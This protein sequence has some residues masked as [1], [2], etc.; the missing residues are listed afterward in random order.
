MRLLILGGTGFL[1]R[2][3]VEAALACGHAVTT[4]TRG[5]TNPD[6]HPQTERLHGDR[7]GALDPLR[8]REWD[9]VIDTSG[10]D[11]RAV[12]ASAAPLAQT[13]VYCFVS[14]R[15]VYADFRPGRRV[16]LIDARDLAEWMIRLVEA[17]V[18][19]IYNAVGTFTMGEVLLTCACV[20][21]SGATFRWVAEDVLLAAGVAPW[22]ELPVWLPETDEYVG[23]HSGRI[24]RAL[25]SGLRFRP[26]AD[27]VAAIL[28]W[29]ATRPADAPWKAG[30]SL[31]RE[32]SILSAARA[33][34]DPS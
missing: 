22:T 18:A 16:T 30:L 20:S 28:K 15:S 25:A 12:E 9:A 19:G 4:F 6:L 8:G 21:N 34:M 10:Q 11:P 17:R 7:L 13:P 2:H 1:G 3:V 27:T 23:F 31:E 26:L 14:T 32:S 33:R 5:V 29:L 24:D